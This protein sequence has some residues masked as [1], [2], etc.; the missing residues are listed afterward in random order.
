MWQMGEGIWGNQEE[1][2]LRLVL[3]LMVSTQMEVKLESLDRRM[4]E[5]GHELIE[6]FTQQIKS[7][8]EGSHQQGGE[9]D[10]EDE[11]SNQEEG[12]KRKFIE[13]REE[14]MRRL[15]VPYFIGEDPYKWIIEWRDT[16]TLTIFM[17]KRRQGSELVPVVGSYNRQNHVVSIQESVVG[18]IP[19]L[20][21]KESM[22]GFN[23]LA[24]NPFH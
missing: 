21:V 22:G 23:G 7:M 17:K 14:R 1:K 2:K 4:E 6:S 8:M 13:R 20:V 19:K 3:E 24:L 10:S 15:E 9:K 11:S 5:M 18:V 12:Y 16:L